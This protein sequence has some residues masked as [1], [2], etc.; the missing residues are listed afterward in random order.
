[1]L[2]IFHFISWYLIKYQILSYLQK[3]LDFSRVCVIEFSYK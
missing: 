1:M 3:L 2:E